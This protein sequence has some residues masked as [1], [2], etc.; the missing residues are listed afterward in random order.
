M[1]NV[2]GTIYA[3][4]ICRM[5]LEEGI[6]AIM[7]SYWQ[8]STMEY[9]A[10]TS[11]GTIL[12]LMWN[13]YYESGKKKVVRI[14]LREI[15]WAWID[16]YILR[17]IIWNIF[18]ELRSASSN[19]NICAAVVCVSPQVMLEYTL[20]F[21]EARWRVDLAIGPLVADW[22]VGAGVKAVW[23]VNI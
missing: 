4:T 21:R 7:Y 23:Q 20:H 11:N 2:A 18:Q 19:K 12:F 6:A 14:L 15:T 13:I 1:R 16:I 9:P 5:L 8:R 17:W 22:Y 10:V 3:S